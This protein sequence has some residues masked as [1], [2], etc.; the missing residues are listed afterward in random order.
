MALGIASGAAWDCELHLPPWVPPSEQAQVEARLAG[1]VDSLRRP[2]LQPLLEQLRQ[3][4]HAHTR[5]CIW[6]R[7]QLGGCLP[8]I[9]MWAGQNTPAES[10]ALLPQ[11]MRAPLRPFWVCPEPGSSPP[12][13]EAPNGAEAGWLSVVA[14]CASRVSRRRP[15]ALAPGRALRSVP[16]RAPPAPVALRRPPPLLTSSPPHGALVLVGPQGMQACEPGA[17]LTRVPPA[18]GTRSKNASSTAGTTC[19]VRDASRCSQLPE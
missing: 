11:A 18:V 2:A 12:S 4:T 19:K 6:M 5:M 10:S 17:N 3:A 13:L 16:P 9:Y 8:H 15:M 1:W 7:V 14:V